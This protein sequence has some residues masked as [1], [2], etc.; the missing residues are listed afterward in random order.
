M[1][2]AATFGQD[3]TEVLPEA[4]ARKVLQKVCSSCHEIESVIVPRRTRAGWQQSV[5]DMIA[6]GADGSNADV[7]AIVEYLVTYFGTVNVNTASTAELEKALGLSNREAQAIVAYRERQ[8]KIKNFDDLKKVPD[9]SAEK[10]QAK[11]G[12][13]AFSQ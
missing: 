12:L 5:D 10:L 7:A 6:R 8:G 4:P 11:R 1:V 9:L 3:K 13:I 2:C